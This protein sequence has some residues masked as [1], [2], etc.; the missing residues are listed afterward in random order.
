MIDK[1]EF[2]QWRSSPITQW[3]LDAI[4]AAADDARDQYLGRFFY[5]SE[6][7]THDAG[8]LRGQFFALMR[9]TP[10]ELTYESVVNMHESGELE[11]DLDGTWVARAGSTQ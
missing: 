5:G 6:R 9:L 1:E 4:V 7:D 10:Q 11:H 8:Y 2:E 3:V